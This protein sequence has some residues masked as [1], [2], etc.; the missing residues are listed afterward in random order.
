[1]KHNFVSDFFFSSALFSAKSLFSVFFPHCH[2]F[3]STITPS[4]IADYR[5]AYGMD[6]EFI[7]RLVCCE[8]G[9]FIPSN[10]FNIFMLWHDTCKTSVIH[11]FRIDTLAN[12]MKLLS[13]WR[14]SHQ[15][16]D[17]S[18]NLCILFSIFIFFFIVFMFDEWKIIWVRCALYA[19]H[20]HCKLIS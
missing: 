13:M 14:I 11:D 10:P 17:V 1:M 8:G 20:H 7:V 16:H 9:N 18:I 15:L 2:R 3:D 4:P 12:E 19:S 5:D 6:R